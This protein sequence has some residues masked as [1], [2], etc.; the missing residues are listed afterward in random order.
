V[1]QQ[2]L[3]K[4]TANGAESQLLPREKSILL[5]IENNPGCR[6]GIIASRLDIPAPTVKKIL[7]IL[8]ERSLIARHG[9]GPGLNYT[10]S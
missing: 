8:V 5:F 1:Q 10:L 6:S 2:L 3:Q 4:L 9:S 7:A